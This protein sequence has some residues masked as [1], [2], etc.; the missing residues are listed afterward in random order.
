M[1]CQFPGD[2]F[3]LCHKPSM[4][5]LQQTLKMALRRQ[6]FI[7]RSAH[8]FSPSSP[9]TLFTPSSSP[10]SSSPFPISFLPSF[11]VILKHIFF[12]HGQLRI[13]Y[14]SRE[15][16]TMCPTCSHTATLVPSAP[17]RRI[18][19]DLGSTASSVGKLES[20]SQ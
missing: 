8:H 17:S 13:H 10:H 3:S 12:C 11:L 14:R 15:S 16:R 20:T 18:K 9:F 4:W 19:A 2:T 6:K 1:Q 7:V 5:H